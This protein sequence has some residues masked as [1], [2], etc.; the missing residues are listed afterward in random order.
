MTEDLTT[1][2]TAFREDF[3]RLQTA[4]GAAVVGAEELVRDCLIALCC[5]GH[6]L[7]E[8]VPGLGKTSLVKAIGQAIGLD[9]GRIQCTPDLM[10]ADI[11][12]THIVDEDG[13]GRRRLTFAR[14]PVFHHLVLVDEIN[15][16]TPKT[17]SALLEVMQ[18][19]QVSAGGEQ[20]PLPAPFFLM[21]TQNPLE[22]AGTYPLPEAQLDRFQF[23]LLVPYPSLETLVTIGQ[24]HSG[25]QTAAVE[26]V[27]SGEAVRSARAFLAA[28]PVAEAVTTYAAR[29]VLASHPEQETAPAA[30]R[31]TLAYG[32][33]P[34]ALQAL[35]RGARVVCA[36][37]G[38]TAVSAEDIRSVAHQSLRHRLI[39]NFEGEADG[40]ATDQLIDDILAAVPAPAVATA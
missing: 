25:L 30:V 7:L 28:L 11:L 20:F 39:V 1:V 14:G 40:I 37:R 19:Q 29:L 21:A 5:N 23:K 32:A 17:Q 18:E 31:R 33:S 38:G 15:R 4:I 26:R 2:Q 10:P 3:Q 35:L 13:D 36:L 34:R 27:W 16:A 24:Q 8:G 12:G 9:T 22:M 6:V